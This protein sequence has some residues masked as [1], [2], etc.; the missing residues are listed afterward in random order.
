MLALEVEEHAALRHQRILEVDPDGAA[1]VASEQNYAAWK[2]G[3]EALLSR[4]SQPSISV[5]T[6]TAFA[7]LEAPK[8]LR[9]HPP[10]QVEMIERGDFERPSGRRFG[11]LVHALLASIDLN[12]GADAIQALAAIDG[13]LVGA[14]EEE[15][16][17]AIVIV[18]SAL[19]HPILQREAASAGEGKLRRETPVL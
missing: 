19:R 2:E 16:Q 13:R 8:D 1:A 4:A 15:I 11:A 3:R 10:V 5:Q 7:R 17:A 18:G 9:A 14:T 12:A 6:V